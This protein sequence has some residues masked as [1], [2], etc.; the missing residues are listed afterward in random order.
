MKKKEEKTPLSHEVVCFQMLY[1]EMLFDT[2]SALKPSASSVI[3]SFWRVTKF[4]VL[5]HSHLVFVPANLYLFLTGVT[6]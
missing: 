6:E 5:M 4:L 3:S 1:F 2:C